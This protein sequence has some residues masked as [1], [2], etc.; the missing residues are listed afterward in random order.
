MTTSISNRAM[1]VNLQISQWTARKL[2][3]AETTALNARHGLTIEAG[4]VNKNLLPMAAEL[5]RVHQ[6][7]SFIRKDFAKRTL[8]WGLEGV[9]ILKADG[10]MEF[11]GVVR[12][13]R[14]DWESA[15]DGFL[16]AYP[17]YHAEAKDLLNGLFREEDYP[18]VDD[19]RR[20]F[21]F[22]IRFMPVPDQQD[23][24]VDI[25]DDALAAIKAQLQADITETMGSAMQAAWQRVHDVVSKA[26]ERLKDPDNVFRD[27][28]VENAVELCSLLPSLNITDD[29]DLEAVRQT[30]ERSLCKHKPD[31]LRD[32][33][34]VREGVTNQMAEIMAKMKGA[35]A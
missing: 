23:W 30:L 26:H 5:E 35:Y 24:R 2:D 7:T 15:V 27:T 28:L 13:W 33:L 32:D 25:G 31:T 22:N 6:T 29:P 14:D 9:N 21:A 16:H 8:P 18:H 1:L 11:T 34:A 4:R 3:R 10:Y 19:L 12:K 20:R 17:T